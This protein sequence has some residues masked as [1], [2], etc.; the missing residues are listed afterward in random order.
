[1]IWPNS[2]PLYLPLRRSR[3]P[4]FLPRKVHAHHVKLRWTFHRLIQISGKLWKCHRRHRL[5]ESINRET[6]RQKRLY[7]KLGGF[8][9]QNLCT[10]LPQVPDAQYSR[11]L[12]VLIGSMITRWALNL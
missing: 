7:H 9:E 1:M 11:L 12:F 4:H 8:F 6:S 3:G 5:A 2:P 10:L